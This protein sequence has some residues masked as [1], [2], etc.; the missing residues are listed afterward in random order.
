M[1]GYIQ[2]ATSGPQDRFFTMNPDYTHFHMT[3]RKHSNFSTQFVDVN[4]QSPAD[5]GDT[6]L[7]KIPSNQGDLLKT[8]SVKMTLPPVPGAFNIYIESVGHALIEYA[9]LIIGGKIVERLTSDYLQIYSEQNMTQTKQAALEKLIGKFPL[10]ISDKRVGDVGA[11]ASGIVS[12][13]ILGL[14]DEETFFVD[15]PF[16]FYRNPELAIPICALKNQEVEVELKLRR[17]QDIVITIEGKLPTLDIIPSIRAFTLSTETIF[18]DTVERIK[19][20]TTRRDYTITQLQ[21]EVF[22]VPHGTNEGTYRL[23]FINPVKE[24]YFVIQRQGTNVNAQDTTSQGNFVTVF[25]YDN[26]EQ[27]VNN[28]LI[29]FENLDTL[30]LTLDD[31]EIITRE[32]GNV[33]F[34]KAVQGAIH[35]SKT[36]LIRRFYSYS[37]A[38]QPEEW[39]P[40]GQINFSLIKEQILHLSLTP[41]PD[42]ARQLRVYALSYT[43]LRVCEGSAQILFGTTV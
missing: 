6:V 22:E 41:C 17:I 37:F 34:L 4:P 13:G 27:I 14:I 32:T 33:M 16:Y 3:F 40:T 10:R 42:F 28:K 31:Q 19:L 20:Q 7:F 11:N 25:D 8:L 39:Y 1:A 18:L 9:D 30:S 36:Q 23:E 2:L 12:S 15:L 26:T 29:L 35:H 24:L 43:I 5:F 38:L 21:R